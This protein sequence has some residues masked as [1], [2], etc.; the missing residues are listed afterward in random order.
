MRSLVAILVLLLAT[1]AR[2]F[3]AEASDRI[4]IDV[5]VKLAEARIVFNLDRP[6]SRATSR[7]AC[8]S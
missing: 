8:S 3:A 2:S 7:P 5:P 1:T 6:V 4:V